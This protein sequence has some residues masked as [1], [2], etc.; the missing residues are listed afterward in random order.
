MKNEFTLF[1]MIVFLFFFDCTK[2]NAAT[3]NQTDINSD[4]VISEHFSFIFYDGLSESISVPVL[5]KLEENY[6]R[7]LRDLNITTMDKITIKIWNSQAHFLDDMEYDIG[8]RYPGAAGY[9]LGPSE[10]RILAR[11][12]LALIALHEFCHTASLVVNRSFSNNPRWLW[13]SVAVY[14]ANE[15]SDPKTIDYLTSGNFP[16]LAELNSSPNAGNLKI[17]KIG[18][19]LSEYIINRWG[20]S[21]YIDMIKYGA[22]IPATLNITVQEFENGWKQFVENKYLK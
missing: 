22:N 6:S 14:E 2:E 21:S 17:Y 16:T 4:S 9:V 10:I 5:S 15:F 8:T 7:V 1:G 11:G 18:Y 20:R 3:Q 19:L 13:E 12:N